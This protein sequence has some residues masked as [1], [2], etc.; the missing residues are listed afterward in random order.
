[1]FLW[2]QKRQRLNVPARQVLRLE[3][4]LSDVQV[5]LPG[6]EPQQA[7]AF[8][9]VFHVSTGLRVAIVLHL[10]T[11]QRL[12]FYLNRDGALD[13]DE[14]SLVLGEGIHFAESLGFMLGNLDFLRMSPAEREQYWESLPIMRGIPATEPGGDAETESPSAAKPEAP[15]LP[16]QKGWTVE[17]MAVK[18]RKFIGNLGRLMGML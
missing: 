2:D 15:V 12:A 6:Q 11:A 1:M 13:K 17:E 10:H 14:A 18:R 4:S 9:C 5:S 7:S 3:R 16:P 8:L